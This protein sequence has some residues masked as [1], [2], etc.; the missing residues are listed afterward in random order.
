M[1]L[2]KKEMF[3]PDET[4]MYEDLNRAH[5]RLEE[6]KET[7]S[8]AKYLIA[9]AKFDSIE[10]SLKKLEAIPANPDEEISFEL[11]KL[12]PKAKNNDVVVH[13]S[14]KYQLRFT[15]IGMRMERTFGKETGDLL[16]I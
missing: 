16:Q 6:V 12:F 1:K 9:S 15:L 11:D 14:G 5:Q 13:E 8:D 7:G 4:V 3:P 10:M 2:G